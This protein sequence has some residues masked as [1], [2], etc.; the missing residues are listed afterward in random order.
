[1]TLNEYQRLAERTVNKGLTYNDLEHHALHG[2]VGEIGEIHSIYQKR[3][4]GHA[5]DEGKLMDE[6]GD[7][8][9]FVAEFAFAHDWTLDDVA[10]MNIEKLK[11]RYPQGFEAER[12]V[13]REV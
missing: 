5:V 4:Q 9:W 10:T 8:M 13:H 12:S 6:L 7:L 11:R 3:Y 1:M 2:M